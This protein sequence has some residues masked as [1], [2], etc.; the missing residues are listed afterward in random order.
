MLQL[1]QDVA[2]SPACRAVRRR[3]RARRFEKQLRWTSATVSV[4]TV[5]LGFSASAGCGSETPTD[6]GE[7]D[8][9]GGNLRRWGDERSASGRVCRTSPR[10]GRFRS[11]PTARTTTCDGLDPE[12]A[13]P[14]DNDEKT[15]GTGIPG[16]N[17]DAC[18]QD[19][20]FGGNSGQ[21]DDGCEW[22]LKCDP[23]ITV[24]A[25]AYD[26]SFKNCPPAASAT[27]IANCQPLVPNGCD[28]FGCYAVQT[29]TLASGHRRSS[30]EVSGNEPA[31]SR[32]CKRI[33]VPRDKSRGT[34]G[35]RKPALRAG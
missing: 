19:C 12:C 26:P 32:V 25:C 10:T 17:V 16:D 23:S 22:S 7:G 30:E 15:F 28:G 27:C 13:G 35:L 8:G 9:D 1:G 2:S 6:T 11:A 14:L 18:K 29:P 3:A 33:P 34:R 20:F 5:G 31:V 21:G 4:V 24:G